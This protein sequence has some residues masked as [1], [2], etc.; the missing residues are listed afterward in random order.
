MKLTTGKYQFLW[1]VGAKKQVIISSCMQKHSWNSKVNCNVNAQYKP[2]SPQRK[3][4]DTPYM[5]QQRVRCQAV[6]MLL[7]SLLLLSVK[8]VPET[9][10]VACVP[11]G[12]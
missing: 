6:F 1:N 9:Y 11:G 3:P 4:E 10:M 12:R 8:P 7:L 5:E 2:D